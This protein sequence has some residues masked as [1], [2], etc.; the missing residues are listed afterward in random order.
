MGGR[1]ASVAA[2]V[3]SVL[4]L[5]QALQFPV[6]T[7]SAPGAGLYPAGVG[8][9]LVVVSAAIVVHGF[10]RGRRPPAAASADLAQEDAA[11]GGGRRVMTA[12][13]GLLGFCL[14]LPW[15]GYP[16]LA[17]LFT[18]LLLQRLG[19]G[20]W[21]TAA[22]GGVVTAAVSHYLFAMLLGVPLPRG[23]L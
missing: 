2:L 6:G 14:L 11:A 9:F 3:A 17:F 8:I 22:A 19:G 5:W 21:A 1:A 15:L 10:L 7:M 20:R 4:Y 18:T 12:V 23:L 13:A 16:L